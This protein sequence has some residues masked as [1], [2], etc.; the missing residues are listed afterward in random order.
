M[1]SQVFEHKRFVLVIIRHHC[2]LDTTNIWASDAIGL[3]GFKELIFASLD[4]EYNSAV[5]CTQL[6]DLTVEGMKLERDMQ[7][8]Y[9]LTFFA[10]KP[11]VTLHCMHWQVCID[12]AQRVDVL[13][14]Q[15][16][17]PPYPVLGWG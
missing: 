12:H 11:P 10:P 14:T 9:Y 16:G 5:P 13:K 6:P 8:R 15:L 7:L 1:E 3:Q 4:I 17:F 2:R